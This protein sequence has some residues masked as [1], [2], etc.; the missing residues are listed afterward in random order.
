MS[1]LAGE[2]FLARF[3]WQDGHADVWRTFEDG[4]TFQT[5][6]D[7]LA[8][9]WV[10]AGITRVIG[11]ESRGFLLGG[12]VAVRLGVGFQAVRKT[13]ALFPG[14]KLTVSAAPDYRGTV[15]DLVMQDTLTESEVVLM[16][17][18][19]AQRGSQAAAVR[20]LVE[21]SRARF[22]GLSVIVDQLNEE[23]RRQLVQVT[24]LVTAEDL[25][26]PDA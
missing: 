3:R 18:D 22:A 1:S 6:V 4:P 24:A 17:D 7:G 10:T 2:A 9:P 15:H 16:V 13:G 11:V 12:A 23:A 8:E 19:W 14:R 21:R 26:D 20:R 5:L 25:G